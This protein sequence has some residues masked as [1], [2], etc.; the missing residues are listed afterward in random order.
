VVGGIFYNFHGK[1]VWPEKKLCKNMDMK[2]LKSDYLLSE[3]YYKAF[4][5]EVE[6]FVNDILEKH[7]EAIHISS[8]SQR[9]GGKIKSQSSIIDN[10]KNPYKYRDIKTLFEIKDIAGV[11]VTCHCEDDLENASTLLEGELLQKYSNVKKEDKGGSNN[12]GK[13]R[14]PYR[15]VHL[16]FSKKVEM[17]SKKTDIFCEV[18]LRTVMA[19]AWAIQDRKYVYGKDSE[20]ETLELTNAVSEIMKGCEKLWSLVK[21]KS[22]RKDLLTIPLEIL[23]IHKETKNRLESIQKT[24]EQ[25]SETYKWISENRRTAWEG[26]TRLGVVGSM[27]VEVVL[28][29][30]HIDI[31]KK[32]LKDFAGRSV[33]RTFGWPIGVFIDSIP[34]FSPKP[35]LHGIHAE[36]SIKKDTTG[37]E[38]KRY[39]YWAINS[40][41]SVYLLKSLFEDS[42]KSQRVFFDTRIV[43]ITEVFLYIKNLYKFF[44]IPS[45]A[46]IEIKITHSG[47]RGR[48]LGAASP[49]RM[50]HSVR[51]SDIE[52]VGEVIKTSLE[53]IEL[54]VAGIVE[55]V[56]KKLFEQFDFFELDNAVLVDIVTN[57]INGKIV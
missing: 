45:T 3:A 19:D 2:V 54:N 34:E 4:Q 49:N 18:Q 40:D 27:E 37:D 43:R 38:E 21:N 7:K 48:T 32:D 26:L 47:L 5:E 22:T 57:F 25:I 29:N 56:T 8:V 9:P 28:P 41:G 17:S 42:R 13:S 14:A 31:A 20:G 33:I 16:T 35:D 12:V 55:K 24:K 51:K 15:A 53:E 39:D 11:R 23:A 50:I 44:N 10:I 46:A 1:T 52:E 6:D 30:Y 36:L